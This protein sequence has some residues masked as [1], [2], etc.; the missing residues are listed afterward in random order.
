MGD[1]VLARDLLGYWRLE[2]VDKVTRGAFRIVSDIGRGERWYTIDGN[3]WKREPKPKLKRR[4]ASPPPPPPPSTDPAAY[5]LFSPERV[6]VQLAIVIEGDV[7]DVKTVLVAKEWRDAVAL[8]TSVT[9][10][11][12]GNG[13]WSAISMYTTIEKAWNHLLTCESAPSGEACDARLVIR[14]DLVSKTAWG[15]IVFEHHQRAAR[16]AAINDL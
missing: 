5:P 11:S 6:V 2:Q 14:R 1:T 3:A 15:N 7:C 9:P 4:A 13:I 16:L 12:S 8:V 10:E